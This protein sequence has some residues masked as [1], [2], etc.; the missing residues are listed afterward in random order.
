MVAGGVGDTV[1]NHLRL[2][3]DG[4]GVGTAT[5]ISMFCT[6]GVGIGSAGWDFMSVLQ[7][8]IRKVRA[9]GEADGTVTIYA[10]TAMVLGL[11]P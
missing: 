9:L 2:L 4:A 1:E 3:R 6:V 5:M 11:A 10:W 8:V 7:S